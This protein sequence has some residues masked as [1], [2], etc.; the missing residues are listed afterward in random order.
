MTN[1]ELFRFTVV[2]AYSG[3]L[4]QKPEEALLPQRS[5]HMIEGARHTALYWGQV[6]K[7]V[8]NVYADYQKNYKTLLSDD[9]AILL[10]QA[11]D[12]SEQFM[13]QAATQY[14]YAL[15]R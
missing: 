10:Q 12:K 4:P 9:E 14:R 2:Q 8:S 6:H 3:I 15:G 7:S 11:R 5:T 13:R 1:E